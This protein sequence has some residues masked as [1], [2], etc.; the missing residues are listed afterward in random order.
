MKVWVE[1]R[2]EGC[3]GWGGGVRGWLVVR[4]GVEV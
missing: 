1:W 3:S 2:C 4:G